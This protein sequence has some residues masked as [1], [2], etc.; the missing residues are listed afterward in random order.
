[1]RVHFVRTGGFAGLQV[2]ANINSDDLPAD[3]AS[4]LMQDIENADF[5]TLP[6]NMTTRGEVDRFQYEITVEEVG[7]KHTVEVGESV[8][9]ESLRPLIRRLELLWRMQGGK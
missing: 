1:M 2:E 3:E 4:A 6:A 8:L 7:K 9:P 5:F